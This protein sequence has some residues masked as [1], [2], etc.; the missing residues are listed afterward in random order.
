M[1]SD[2]NHTDKPVQVFVHGRRICPSRPIV[3][4]CANASA[5]SCSEISKCLI[6]IL[7]NYRITFYLGERFI[8]KVTFVW[9]LTRMNY[10]VFTQIAIG[11]KFF[12]TFLTL[13]RAFSI[14][15][16]HVNF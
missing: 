15:N 1:S 6:D 2:R 7:L 4:E 10:H 8:T 14:V 3:G 13:V 12:P 5:N 11:V 16:A 9:F